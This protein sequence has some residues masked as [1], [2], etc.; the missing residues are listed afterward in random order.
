[1]FGDNDKG[2]AMTEIVEEG[3]TSSKSHLRPVLVHRTQLGFSSPHLTRRILQ[4][5]RYQT[6]TMEKEATLEAPTC[7]FCILALTLG[8]PLSDCLNGPSESTCR[9]A[10]YIWLA[11]RYLSAEN[12]YL[13]NGEMKPTTSSTSLMSKH[14]VSQLLYWRVGPRLESNWRI[15][16]YSDFT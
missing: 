6:L 7:K 3:P 4:Y 13:S 5:A 11:P 16:G 14:L 15:F 8:G 2:L 1:V 9:L 10:F 12:A